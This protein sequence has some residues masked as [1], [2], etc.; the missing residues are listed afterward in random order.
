MLTLPIK[1]R[2][3][4]QPYLAIRA[5][6]SRRHV[7]RQG[8]LFLTEVLAYISAKGIQSYG[9]SFFRHLALDADGEM[10]MEFG[11]FTEKLHPGSGPIRSGTLP[12]GSFISVN[13]T[14]SYACLADVHLMM[15]GWIGASGVAIDRTVTPESTTYGCRIEIHHVAPPIQPNPEKWQTEIAIMIKSGGSAD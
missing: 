10:D 9:P 4:K 14:G 11:Y 1:I 3:K 2:R 6:L 7:S 5:R 12:S 8:P 15:T 13:W